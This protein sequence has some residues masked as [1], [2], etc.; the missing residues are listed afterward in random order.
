MKMKN[1]FLATFFIAVT[2]SVQ[3]KGPSEKKPI[4]GVYGVCSSGTENAVKIELTINDDFT[5]HYFDNNNPSKILDVKGNWSMENN[6]IVLKDYTS[7][8]SIHNKWKVDNNEN[9]LKS[10]KGLEYTR[11]CHLKSNKK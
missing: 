8:F 5:F 7:A 6:T 3:A 2:M 4:S 9:C 1:L 10:R 11:L